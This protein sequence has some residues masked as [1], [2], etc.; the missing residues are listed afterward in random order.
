MERIFHGDSN[1]AS[2]GAFISC[3]SMMYSILLIMFPV[4]LSA[5]INIL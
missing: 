3:D 2:N 4:V 1:V 5:G